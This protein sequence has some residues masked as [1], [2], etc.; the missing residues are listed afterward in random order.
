MKKFVLLSLAVFAILFVIITMQKNK[1]ADT[2]ALQKT[3]T[4]T[5]LEKEK[6]LQFWAHYRQA[7]DYRL[8]DQWEAAADYY[9]RALKLNDKHE[10][11]LYYLGN[12]YFELARYAEAEACWLKLVEVN[13][14]NSRAY[15]QL[16]SLYLSSEDFFD[17]EKAERACQE[18]LRINKEE[19]GPLLLLGEV[20]LIRGRLDAAAANFE[21]VTA[22]NFR[23]TEAYFLGGYI[24][25]KK[26][27]A[28][29]ARTLFEQAVR[30]AKPVEKKAGQVEG[31]GDTKR[32]R[33][34]GAVTSKSVFRQFMTDLSTVQPNRVGPT[35]EQTYRR[36]DAFLAALQ[37]RI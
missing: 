18:S 16:G 7:T 11:A 22:S 28:E 26:G 1:P 2:A 23:S 31:E 35:L 14:R 4:H 8:E 36:L 21:A 15:L 33:G 9:S 5:E 13:P 32:G 12:M 37:S 25:W 10:D 19:T 27:A 34:F 17:I 20:E 6:V 3:S 29:K 24:A 30:Y